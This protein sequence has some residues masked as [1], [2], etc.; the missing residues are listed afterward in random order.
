M[1]TGTKFFSRPP[2]QLAGGVFLLTV[3]PRILLN[4]FFFLRFGRHASHLIEIW[5]YY[6]LSRGVFSLSPLDPT[7]WLL[8]PL[9]RLLPAGILYPAVA[10]A[11]ALVSAFTAVLVFFWISSRFDRRTGWWAGLAF[12]LEAAPLTLCLANFSHDII[13]IPMIV[14]FFWAFQHWNRSG[15]IISGLAAGGLAIVGFKVGPLMGGALPAL[16]FYLL[17]RGWCRLRRDSTSPRAGAIF[18]LA[19]VGL[20]AVIYHLAHLYLLDALIPLAE[21]F[22]G[23]DLAA[24]IK[25]KVGDLQPLP[26]E[27]LWNRYNFL[28]LF[29]PAG[30]WLAYRKR[31]FLILSLLLTSL[32]LGLVVNRGARLLDLPVAILAGMALAAKKQKIDRLTLSFIG[33]LIALNLLFSSLAGRLHLLMPMLLLKTAWTQLRAGGG[34][35]PGTGLAG[36]VAACLLLGILGVFIRGKRWGGGVLIGALLFL[37]GGWV[38][39][40]ATASSDELEYQAYR[41][42]DARAL[43]GEKIFAAWNQGYFIPAV[44]HL[45]PVT[46][47]ERIDLGLTR[48]YWESE[49]E[50]WRTLKERGVRYVH[51]NT[52]YFALTHVDPAR[53]RF[54]IRGNTII[55]PRPVHILTFSRMR[56]TFLYRLTYEPKSLRHFRVIYDRV[57]RD[58]RIGVRIF[59]L[60]QS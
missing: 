12:G 10:G 25:I 8:R 30:I 3:I 52:R 36:I 33:F 44:T 38:F 2:A 14:L 60:K 40:S 7:T 18:A 16:G 43:P 9:G 20:A 32:A 19:L 31:S 41:W 22:R 26:G 6:G 39:L 17:W 54:S 15:K 37:Q 29:L 47:P 55:G 42:L 48:I 46:T 23:I 58:H 53:D 59:A 1:K 50:A 57:D 5:F 28:L 34:L 24:Q 45:L 27:A 49:E 13:Q 51:I 4:I 56:R 35:S 11:G 21:K